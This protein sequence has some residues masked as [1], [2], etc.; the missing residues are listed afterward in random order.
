[1][2]EQS[3]S[4]DFDGYWVEEHWGSLPAAS[5]VY[6]VYACIYRKA[7]DKVSLRRLLYIGESGNVR[8]RVPEDPKERRDEWEDELAD[9]EVL[10]VS[11]AKITPADAR[12][13]A[14][15]AMINHHEPP[16]NVEYVLCFPF[17]KTHV[18]TSGEKAKLIP[19]FTVE[20]H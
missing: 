4:L 13:R 16:C 5:G 3:Y 7:S 12:R 2:A 18:S 17:D 15:A 8:R 6:C 19:S 11:C 14:E 10:C 1:M 9:D 20:R